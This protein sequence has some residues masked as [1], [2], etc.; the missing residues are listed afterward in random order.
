MSQP[1]IHENEV[2]FMG[3]RERI[4]AIRL[5]EMLMKDPQRAKTLGLEG[6]MIQKRSR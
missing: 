2:I 6:R 3:V 5:L 1:A 4:R